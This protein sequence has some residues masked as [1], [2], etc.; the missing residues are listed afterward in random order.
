MA[1]GI[2]ASAEKLYGCTSKST[3]TPNYIVS[4]EKISSVARGLGSK[5]KERN[6]KLLA[7]INPDAKVVI[8]KLFEAKR[9]NDA[10]NELM[11][12]SWDLPPKEGAMEA[13]RMLVDESALK[14]DA[15]KEALTSIKAAIG[16]WNTYYEA[17]RDGAVMAD[18][19]GKFCTALS[20]NCMNGAKAAK[21]AR[22]YVG[23][24]VD[25]LKPAELKELQLKRE[26]AELANT[27]A[28]YE[29]ELGENPK[30]LSAVA[31]LATLHANNCA[32]GVKE[33]LQVLGSLRAKKIDKT[34]EK[35]AR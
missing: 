13:S 2:D 5:D 26:T 29:K 12:A 35:S 9:L 23:N 19:L 14:G 25:G 27:V 1:K 31:A 11:K 20:K 24:Y 16:K 18:K 28:K 6:K 34:V 3:G 33:A 17:C 30:N 22:T 32:Y 8:T 21:S 4:M 15:S 7:K 10:T